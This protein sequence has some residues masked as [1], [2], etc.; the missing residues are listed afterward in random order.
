LC[1]PDLRSLLST[2]SSLQLSRTE[3]SGWDKRSL[4]LT[5]LDWREMNRG[6]GDEWGL[7]R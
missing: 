7:E 1:C 4:K 6:R 5:V 2:F 3:V